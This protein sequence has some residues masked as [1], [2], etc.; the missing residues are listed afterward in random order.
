MIGAFYQFYTTYEKN[1]QDGPNDIRTLD[2]LTILLLYPSNLIMLLGMS[3]SIKR[4][5]RTLARNMHITRKIATVS[6]PL[7]KF[8]EDG[9]AS[10]DH[11]SAVTEEFLPT[12]E[13][14]NAFFNKISKK[15]SKKTLKV[16]F[17]RLNEETFDEN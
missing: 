1:Y 17:S 10:T 2:L 9:G 16:R 4:A 14:D 13:E 7:T 6:R 15:L 11:R 8:N 5:M 12:T 3:E